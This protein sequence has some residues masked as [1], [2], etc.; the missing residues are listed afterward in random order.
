MHVLTRNTVIILREPLLRRS[1]IRPT[2]VLDGIQPNTSF[3]RG[4][5]REPD[6]DSC[7][8]IER[9]MC[10]TVTQAQELLY[11]AEKERRQ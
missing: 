8:L 5:E 6:H 4:S 11:S 7:L 10:R 3:P 2:T 1:S 9:D